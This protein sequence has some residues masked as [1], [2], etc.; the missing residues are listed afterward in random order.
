MQEKVE[1][2][3]LAESNETAKHFGSPIFLPLTSSLLHRNRSM[4]HTRGRCD[5][6]QEGCES[7][8]YHLHRYLNNSIRLHNFHFSKFKVQSSKFIA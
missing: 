8:Y 6:R 4:S 1:N 5:G 3:F 2:L 7:G